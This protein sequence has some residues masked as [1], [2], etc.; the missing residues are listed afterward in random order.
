MGD[1]GANWRFRNWRVPTRLTAILLVPVLTGVTFAGLRVKDQLDLANTAKQNEQIAV[2]VRDAATV[3]DD[4]ET[5]RDLAV[6]PELAGVRDNPAV[7]T[8][9]RQT[10]TDI[11]TMF[12]AASSVHSDAQISTDLSNFRN[13]ESL[14]LGML[15]SNGN[16]KS[17]DPVTTN[18]DY[19][20]LFFDLMGL[21]NELSFGNNDVNSRGRELY[22]LTLEKASTS[23][24]RNLVTVALV[25]DRM[26]TALSVGV[27]TANK[28]TSTAYGQFVVS[29][30]PTDQ[31]L[32][33]RTV[34]APQI[35]PTEDQLE[36]L[37]LANKPLA[38][39]GVTADSWYKSATDLIQQERSVESALTDQIVQDARTGQHNAD[40]QAII[41]AA[42]AL[43]ALLA[44]AL[45]TMVMAR[46][47]VRGMRTL[48]DSA[49]DIASERL[50][51]LVRKLSKTDPERVDT[52]VAPIPLT[53]RDEIGE[54]ARAFEDV[55]REAVRLAS[56]QAML[57]GN[58]N[59][60]FTNLSRRSQ[61]LIER[62]LALITELETNEGDPDQLESLFKLDHLATR[63]RRNGENLLVL[64]GESAGREWNDPI[65]LVDV[66][67]AA[68][69]EVEQYE[70]VELSG[71]P[72]TD[73][74]G[75]AVTDL[76]HLLAEL[77]ENATTFSSPQ[78]KV[79]VTATRLPDQRV[80][81]EIH[82]KGIGL[83]AEDF[84]AI[85]SKLADPP[86]VDA[87]VSRQMGLFVV[88][89]L[90][91]RHG[92][93]VQLRPSG[94]SAGTTS[95][96]MVPD[97]LTQ[98]PRV[99]EPEEQFTVSRVY[100][101]TGTGEF[102]QVGGRS[103]SDLG[104]D[105]SRYEPTP[106]LPEAEQPAAALGPVQR[107]LRLGQRRE[108]QALEPGAPQPGQPTAGSAAP[109]PAAPAAPT[110]PAAPAAPQP[111]AAPEPRYDPGFAPFGGERYP[112]QAPYQEPYPAEPYPP[113]TYTAEPYQDGQRYAADFDTAGPYDD[114]FPTTSFP[115][116]AF[117]DQPFQEQ[118]YEEQPYGQDP[119][120]GEQPYAG[121]PAAAAAP[122]YEEQAYEESGYEESGYEES[123]YG[124]SYEGRPYA[125][126]DS[127]FE[128][129]RYTA[130][131]FDSASFEPTRAEPAVPSASGDGFDSTFDSGYDRFGGSGGYPQQ[132]YRAEQPAPP[133]E[134][135]PRPSLPQRP[136]PA[137]ALPQ[138]TGGGLPQRR[139]GQAL[140]GRAI[141]GRESGEHPN[142]FTGARE[143]SGSAA[144]APLPQ[145]TVEAVRAPVAGGTTEAG[146][147]RRVP[148]Q[149][150][151]PGNVQGPGT[152]SQNPAAQLSRNPEE[153]R[154]RLTNLR[155]G[156]Q[157][158][159]SAG[160]TPLPD[161]HGGA[162]L[163]GSP[164]HP[165]R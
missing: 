53:G 133:V 99:G 39:S 94:E 95:L 103:A 111:E 32:Y 127:S 144:A 4:L 128:V 44:S 27:Q 109:A 38:S 31:A 165:E 50:P 61:G 149:N 75:L 55:H 21:D 156:V 7:L 52:T 110:A 135:L 84:A 90:A 17:L 3:V 126:P 161:Q 79:R 47:M 130:A 8:A 116:A 70:R 43:A 83:T 1:G 60:I 73:V 121:A 123:P 41:L 112:E 71:I 131:D 11:T 136:S 157:Q 9:Q 42:E 63:M 28:L 66:L 155:R 35:T 49:Q 145:P 114:G 102:P 69:S 91:E 80:L 117:Q 122:A 20:N 146:L 151:L 159:R 10:N 64:A 97:H 101:E 13:L 88:G 154:G 92:I 6:A 106:A 72:E 118:P 104:F 26:P 115:A 125:A 143:D 100:P 76:V 22:A 33:K 96:V 134:P 67:R 19:S 107:A 29:G 141:G 162:D 138:S 160:D 58:V 48:R 139:P 57:R 119:A 54:V 62:Q 18:A 87:T 142:W 34:T 81:I 68:A 113:E 25:S 36:T 124:Q 5:E 16:S 59:A 140:G 46:S 129:G 132:P 51:D 77:L 137:P 93:R 152:D 12:A 105:D 74:I 65:P 56:E 23:N 164:N 82:D 86:T 37:G 148:R 30:I 163:F 158:G 78:T 89:R 40:Q 14:D 108:T 147:P 150:L 85:N 24:E 120:Y 153:V 98:L 2:L 45:L 15:R